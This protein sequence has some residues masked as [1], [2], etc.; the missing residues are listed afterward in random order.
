MMA[1]AILRTGKLSKCGGQWKK[2]KP[3]EV[4]NTSQFFQVCSEEPCGL[5]MSE[6][7]QHLENN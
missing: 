7:A 2:I 5:S 3:E 4:E 1:W 6:S